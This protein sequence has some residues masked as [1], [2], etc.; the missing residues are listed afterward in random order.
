MIKQCPDSTHATV[1]PRPPRRKRLR[2]ARGAALWLLWAA[3]LTVAT[4]GLAW[5]WQVWIAPAGA[6]SAVLLA[7]LWFFRDPERPLGPGCVLAAADG[8]VTHIGDLPDGRTRITT[9]LSPLDVHV[10]RAPVAGTVTS[11]DH[12]PGG[13]RP[14]FTKESDQNERMV[15]HL[16]TE[17]GVVEL[18]Q[19][20]GTMVRRIVPYL[21]PGDVVALGDRIGLIR[22]GSRVDVYLPSGLEPA[23]EVG[24][25]VSAGKTP[26]A[27]A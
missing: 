8:R 14:A 9:Y 19:I 23:V 27:H 20:A 11:V 26:L 18:V 25:R 15:W 6:A 17:F 1:G 12:R 4:A 21:A 16:D 5:R 7:L 24:S 22:F 3:A 13:H 10:V 2:L